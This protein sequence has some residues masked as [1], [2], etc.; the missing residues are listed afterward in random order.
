LLLEC[1]TP[2]GVEWGHRHDRAL[3]KNEQMTASSNESGSEPNFGR[4]YYNSKA[5]CPHDRAIKNHHT[6]NQQYLQ[7]DFI[8]A[9]KISGVSTQGLGSRYVESYH[10]YYAL[11]IS[12]FHCFVDENGQYKVSNVM[13]GWCRGDVS[14]VGTQSKIQTLDHSSHKEVYKGGK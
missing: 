13:G 12:M 2:F 11:D 10:L 5:W 14:I 8:F 4:L 6:R 7:I 3:V 9:R 1:K